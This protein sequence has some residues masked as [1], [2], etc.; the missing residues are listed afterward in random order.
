MRGLSV[1]DFEQIKMIARPHLSSD[2]EKI[3]YLVTVPNGDKYKTA[4]EVVDRKTGEKLWGIDEDN[5]TN[6]SW[7][8]YGD[9]ILF[10]SRKGLNDEKGTA[11]RRT[12][13]VGSIIRGLLCA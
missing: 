12:Q 8:P 11:K 5:P 10:T 2:A 6:P 7:S 3:L 13:T 4:L 1:D 9:M